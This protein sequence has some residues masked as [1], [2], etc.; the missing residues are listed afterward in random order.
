MR[1]VD[2]SPD[3]DEPRLGFRSLDDDEDRS[4]EPL[5]VGKTG[6]GEEGGVY[7]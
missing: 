4:L 7:E 2:L 6:C 3:G 1:R 5:E